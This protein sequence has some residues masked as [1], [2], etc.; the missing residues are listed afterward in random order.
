MKDRMGC[1]HELIGL[2]RPRSTMRRV[3]EGRDRWTLFLYSSSTPRN[4]F[5]V[6]SMAIA[7]CHVLSVFWRSSRHAEQAMGRPGK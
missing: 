2:P 4:F 3:S 6:T 7:C 5:A 1:A